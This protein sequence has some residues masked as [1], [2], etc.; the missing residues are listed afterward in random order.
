MLLIWSHN[1]QSLQNLL[2]KGRS[3]SWINNVSSWMDLRPV[4]WTKHRLKDNC[5]DHQRQFNQY[6][7]GNK[8]ILQK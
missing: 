4:E 1:M 8:I 7:R 2:V 5:K 6:V 3:T